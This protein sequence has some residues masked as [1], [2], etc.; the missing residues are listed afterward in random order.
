MMVVGVT[1]SVTWYTGSAQAS[2][3]TVS[4]ALSLASASGT[5]NQAFHSLNLQHLDRYV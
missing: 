4:T 2:A 3:S 5:H 1:V